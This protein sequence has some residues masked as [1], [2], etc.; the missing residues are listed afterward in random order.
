MTT[1]IA[2]PATGNW[3]GPVDDVP[4]PK[5]GSFVHRHRDPRRLVWG[6]IEAP[7]GYEQERWMARWVQEHPGVEVVWKV[8]WGVELAG[9][10]DGPVEH[11]PSPLAEW[12]WWQ[13]RRPFYRQCILDL[14]GALNLANRHAAA[15]WGA[16]RAQSIAA[17]RAI[18]RME[19]AQQ[20]ARD[21]RIDA[22]T[23][24]EA[25]DGS[26]ERLRHRLA[27]ADG[28]REHLEGVVAALRQKVTDERQRGD[29]LLTERDEVR[30]DYAA[31]MRLAEKSGR[32]TLL[33]E[34]FG[35]DLLA[36]LQERADD[37]AARSSVAY[38]LRRW[39]AA[40]DGRELH[41]EHGRMNPTAAE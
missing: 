28:A 35:H 21:Q 2:T 26:N 30:A 36:K 5:P 25:A 6:S 39:Q 29:R 18:G 17:A 33:M 3:N 12:R 13:R 7:P 27:E 24:A 19:D 8:D 32:R 38:W 15:G 22:L 11:P 20:E 40:L 10:P 9:E 4:C 37:R 1:T 34:E 23:L 14:R 41:G 16:A 31:A